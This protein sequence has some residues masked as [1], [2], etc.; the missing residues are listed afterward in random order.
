MHPN[1]VHI[2]YVSDGWPFSPYQSY[3]RLPTNVDSVQH[4]YSNLYEIISVC[5]PHLIQMVIHFEY[6]FKALLH[7]RCRKARKDLH[8][9]MNPVKQK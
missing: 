4:E 1:E 6:A 5:V 3:W 8:W 9:G 7:D 2:V